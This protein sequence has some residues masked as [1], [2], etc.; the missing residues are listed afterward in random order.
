MKEHILVID[1]D[2]GIRLLLELYLSRFYRVTTKEN[3][4]EAIRWM[5]NG[6]LPDL[7]ITDINMPEIGG[8]EFLKLIR[9]SGFFQDI[10]VVILTGL[11]EE[12][13]KSKCGFWGAKGFLTKPF[14]PDNLLIM[15]HMLLKATTIPALVFSQIKN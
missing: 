4:L 15:I 3:G 7:I 5:E 10:P 6:N 1:D 11:G 14:N 2:I 9:N 13:V 8:Y 12:E